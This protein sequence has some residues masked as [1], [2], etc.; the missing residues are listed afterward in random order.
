MSAVINVDLVRDQLASRNS[1]ANRVEK[2]V[3]SFF[4]VLA[5]ASR[6]RTTRGYT[7][8]HLPYEISATRHT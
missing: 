4:A 2:T 7:E 1:L 6:L 8:R 3:L 5:L